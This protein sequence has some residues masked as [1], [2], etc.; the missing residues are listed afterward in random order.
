[1]KSYGKVIDLIIAL[2]AVSFLPRLSTYCTN[3][4]NPLIRSLDQ[5]G[6][7]LWISVH[8]IL[9]LILTVVVMAFYFNN[10]KHWGFV[11]TRHEDNLKIVGWFLVAYSLI[12]VMVAVL[13]LGGKGSDFGHPLSFKNIFGHYCF[14]ALIS[15]T[16]EEPLFRG[17][18]VTVL[19]QSWKGRL[20][21]GKTDFSVAGIL[22]ALL[23]AFAHIGFRLHPFEIFRLSPMQLLSAFGY[24]LLYAV[25]FENT[26]SLFLP[27]V[28]HNAANVI[29]ITIQYGLAVL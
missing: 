7:F 17:F 5:D 4:L 25:L 6:A 11:F 26:N 21:V 2:V 8:H 28:L 24:G 27:I 10:L 18:A 23:F 1:M 16:C 14:Q 22:A 15:G 19:A 9:M 3:G 20:R 13:I 29:A 12:E